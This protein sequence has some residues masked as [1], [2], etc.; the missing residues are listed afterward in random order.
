M[1]AGRVLWPRWF[2]GAY[3][4]LGVPLFHYCSPFFYAL[5]AP[6]HLLG[7]PLDAAVKLIMTVLFV[8]SG[9]AMYAWLRRLL[10]PAAGLVGATLYLANPLFFR[11]YYFQGD[12]PQTFAL[13]WFPVVL[14]A[15]TRLYEDDRWRNWLLASV[16]LAVLV[17]SHNITA[18]LGAAFLVLYWLALPFW[19]RS[20]RGWWRGVAAAALGAALSAFFWL[21]A[22]GDSPLVRVNALREG[23]FQ[24]SLHFVHLSDLLAVPPLLDSRVLNPAFSPLAG[25]GGLAGA[26]GGPGRRHPAGVSARP[27]GLGPD[28][29]GRWPRD[30]GHLSGADAGLERRS[31]G[32]FARPEPAA[33][34]RPAVGAG[35]RERGLG[36]GGGYTRRT[37]RA[38]SP[39]PWQGPYSSWRSAVAYSYSRLSPLSG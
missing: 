19:R 38:A 15:F 8:V 34:P 10:S 22:L 18:M 2:P 30:H 33:V 29:G 32:A 12:Y 25:V 37:R 11:E 14:W 7:L 31:M 23:F 4:G 21:P 36:R 16:S 1:D 26:G 27:L 13:F 5:V 39:S 35:G 20:W 28:L 24:F 17:V 9:L 3:E 6:L